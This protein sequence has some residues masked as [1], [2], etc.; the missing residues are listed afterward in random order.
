MLRG[1]CGILCVIAVWLVRLEERE[2]TRLHII[3]VC[4]DH[5]SWGASKRVKGGKKRKTG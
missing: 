3:N 1:F 4:K 5:A 2:T